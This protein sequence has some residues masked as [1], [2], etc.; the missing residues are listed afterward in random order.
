MIWQGP[1]R[2][3]LLPFSRALDFTKSL[4]FSAIIQL[5]KG[6][7]VLLSVVAVV[8]TAS[9]L[10]GSGPTLEERPT[11]RALTLVGR[12]FVPGEKV[13]LKVFAERLHT[14]TASARADGTLVARIPVR[15]HRCLGWRVTAVGTRSGR[16]TFRG[17]PV[18]CPPAGAALG[19]PPRG[20]TGLAGLVSRGP[21]RPVCI[22]ELSCDGPAP[23]VVVVVAV[24]DMVV[25]RAVTGGDGRYRL[26]LPPGTY[27]VRAVA[28]RVTPSSVQAQ[29]RVGSF[30][31][32]SF[33][34][35]TGIR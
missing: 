3:R 22:A 30:A 34:I 13:V 18:E 35:D 15:T 6:L 1:A 20:G 24:E 5:M 14:V 28:R 26:L 10:A 29:V 11:D 9:A 4:A 12:G 32:A 21:T 7:V 19:P 31:V 17:P 16:L 25:A 33:S 2:S 23:G 8:L 27:V